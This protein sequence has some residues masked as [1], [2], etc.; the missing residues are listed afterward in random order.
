MSEAARRIL[1][2]DASSVAA[3][4]RATKTIVGDQFINWEPESLWLT[5]ERSDI[6]LSEINRAKIMAGVALVLVPSYYWD[7]IVFEKTA[8]AMDGRVPN[9][10]ALEEAS[11]AQL[12]W[13]TID[14]AQVRR[15]NDEPVLDFDHEPTAY[16][17]VI[18]HRA[19]MVLAP[20]ELSFAQPTLDRERRHDHLMD[21]VK[22]RWSNMDHANLASYKLDE[23]PIDVQLAHLAAV[24]LHV[25]ERRL[26]MNA[27]LASL[28]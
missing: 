18:M 28:R 24:G 9:P 21:D 10:D 17:A 13:S 12:A 4:M 5:L 20:D 11:A 2:N 15:D 23:T 25:K 16:A 3:L 19:G 27:E 6:D 26:A 22:K 14:A 8:I 1:R 7:A